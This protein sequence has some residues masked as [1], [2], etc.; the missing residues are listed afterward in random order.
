MKIKANSSFSSWSNAAVSLRP[1]SLSLCAGA[2]LL[3]FTGA[4]MADGASTKELRRFGFSG[5]YTGIVRG[6]LLSRTLPSAAFTPVPVSELVTETLP[7]VRQQKI[8]SPFGIGSEYLLYVKTVVNRRRAV[9]RGLYYGESLNP[10][11]GAT[12][13]KTGTKVLQVKRSVSRG[14]SSRMTLADNM[15]EFN[16]A[17]VLLA[18]WKKKGTLE[19]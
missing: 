13:V 15:N 18:Q 8:A 5:S 11:L 19:K 12:T 3:I 9:I 1:L 2:F 16:S 14:T 4:A 7:Q 17:G 10:A 6:T